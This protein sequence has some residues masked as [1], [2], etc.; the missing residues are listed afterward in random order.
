[1]NE[2]R[3]KIGLISM[4]IAAQLGKDLGKAIKESIPDDAIILNQKEDFERGSLAI[5]L[6]HQNFNVIADGEKVPKMLLDI[7]PLEKQDKKVILPYQH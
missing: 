7:K 3:L 1:M 4:H 5:I 2:R 6:Y